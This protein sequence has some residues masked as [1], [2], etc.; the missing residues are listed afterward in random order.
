VCKRV[1]KMPLLLRGPRGAG[2]TGRD[3][4]RRLGE[5]KSLWEKRKGPRGTPLKILT[6]PRSWRNG[7]K[8][9]WARRKNSGKERNRKRTS[10][11]ERAGLE[12][13]K[14]GPFKRHTREGDGR[15]GVTT[16]DLLEILGRETHTGAREG[17]RTENAN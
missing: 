1:N 14:R 8:R 3:A 9:S 16:D 17:Q 15:R 5:A 13:R 2:G 7:S 4:Q 11:E 12:I 10:D 6:V